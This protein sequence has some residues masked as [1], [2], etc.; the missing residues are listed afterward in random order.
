MIRSSVRSVVVLMVVWADVSAQNMGTAPLDGRRFSTL[1]FSRALQTFL[2][3]GNIFYQQPFK[4]GL[5][6]FRQTRKSR[7]IRSGVN[8]RQDEWGTLLN[9][10][11]NLSEHWGVAGMGSFSSLTDNQ[12][13]GLGNLSRH[14]LL[15]GPEYTV[16]EKAGA[17]AMGGY[18][19]ASQENTHDR[20]F[21]ALGR[22]WLRDLPVEE[23]FLGLTA[24]TDRSVLRPRS[25]TADSISFSLRREFSGTS[26]NRLSV[27]VTHQER[28]FYVVADPAVRQDFQ[29]ENNIYRRKAVEAGI[30]DTLSVESVRSSLLIVG[31]F[32]SRTIDRG[33]RYK[34]FSNPSAIM[35]DNRIRETRLHGSAAVTA[36]L[37]K[38]LETDARVTYEEREE[39]HSV[40]DDPLVT[41]QA[42]AKQDL[43]AKRLANTAARTS[44]ALGLRSKISEKDLLNLTGSASILRYDTPDS[45][46]IDDRDEMLLIFGIE[47]VHRFS[48]SLN[49]SLLADVTLSHLVYLHRLQSANNNWNRIVRLR[50]E[51]DY[52]PDGRLKTRVSAE[53]V[54][55]YT[56]YDFEDQALSIKSFSFRQVSWSDSTVWRI[57]R[58]LSLTVLA[59]VRL[60]ERG[61][62]KWDEFKE[63]PENYFV[64][65]SY[66]PQLTAELSTGLTI[67][68]GYRFFS[69][70][71]FRYEG[72]SR[73]PEQRIENSGPTVSVA[74]KG[75]DNSFLALEGW[76][77]VQHVDGVQR[78]VFSNMS[79]L[80]G[81]AL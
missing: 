14:R 64:E 22:L 28:E 72:R 21:S 1:E 36:R 20:G 42:Y 30:V 43:A 5:V 79:F 37:L 27:L 63:R 62:L 74:W 56:V 53:V 78:Q 18:E 52:V 12:Q 3:S 68:F 65:Q 17:V 15:L 41:D 26:L 75:S 25:L 45:L 44:L 59:T 29:R 24:G 47:G 13:L 23:F 4:D 77:E 49:L 11:T 51:V 38:W 40:S 76:R 8:A 32:F 57:G 34:S 31:G 70:T 35:L 61:I 7:L 81:M 33:Y 50:S 19:W 54:A 60:Y 10:S 46:N 55:N 6:D 71:R 2:W 58:G 16:S 73:R 48:R 66:W 9:I 39:R 69:Q 80:V 67:S